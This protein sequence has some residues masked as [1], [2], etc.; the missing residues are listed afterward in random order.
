MAENDTLGQIEARCREIRRSPYLYKEL[1]EELQRLR[2]V[3]KDV[4][5]LVREDVPYLIA[6]IK[7]LRAGQHKRASRAKKTSAS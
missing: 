7:Q 5:L 2:S 6:E 3:L 1:P 4:D